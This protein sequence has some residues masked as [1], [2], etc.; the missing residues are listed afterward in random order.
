PDPPLEE[1]PPSSATGPPAETPADF[2]PIAD[3]AH[4]LLAASSPT[5][6]SPLRAAYAAFVAAIL[7]ADPDSR[8]AELGKAL[9]TEFDRTQARSGPTAPTRPSALAVPAARLAG[10]PSQPRAR[11]TSLK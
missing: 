7:A 9:T 3:R 6:H 4:H 1:P 5:D 2:R 11:P 8:L 10:Q